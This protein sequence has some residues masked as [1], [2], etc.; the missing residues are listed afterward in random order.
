MSSI[1]RTNL[2]NLGVYLDPEEGL[3][4]STSNLNKEERHG[5][6]MLPGSISGVQAVCSIILPFFIKDD[7]Q[8]PMVRLPGLVEMNLSD[9]K[10]VYPVF[11]NSQLS[12]KSFTEGHLTEAGSLIFNIIDEHPF[13]EVMNRY[14]KFLA[15]ENKDRIYKPQNLPPLD[16]VLVFTSRTGQLY[17]IQV[18]GMK[19][20]DSNIN[21][22]MESRPTMSTVSFICKKVKSVGSLED[23]RKSLPSLSHPNRIR[24]SPVQ[25]GGAETSTTGSSTASTTSTT[26]ATTATVTTTATTATLV[27]TTASSSTTA[28]TVTSTT[29]GTSHSPPIV[30]SIGPDGLPLTGDML[31]E[32]SVTLDST[33]ASWYD[34]GVL[35]TGAERISITV[36]PTPVQDGTDNCYPEGKY[37]S[38]STYNPASCIQVY[39]GGTGTLASSNCRPWSVV[40]A[41]SL[42]TP[43]RSILDGRQINRAYEETGAVG[44]LWLQFNDKSGEYGDNTGTF[45]I[46]VQVFEA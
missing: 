42:T 40:G 32:T 33:D 44:K 22:T 31:L 29:A 24:L 30:S 26:T 46:N 7:S 25:G 19:I 2:P 4:Y 6:S 27:V 21:I 18:A 43:G 5:L 3:P 34:T 10:D 13:S 20:V 23:K 35:L 41:I 1:N 45:N 8:A 39:S 14:N 9:H 17:G 28:T 15:L 16:A 12:F 11:A 36:S 38:Y 37:A